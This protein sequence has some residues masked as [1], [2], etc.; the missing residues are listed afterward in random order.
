M[1]VKRLLVFLVA[2]A[3]VHAGSYHRQTLE[4]TSLMS[5]LATLERRHDS[6]LDCNDPG[7]EAECRNLCANSQAKSCSGKNL[8]AVCFQGMCYCGFQP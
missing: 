4:E 7:L 3:T 1:F 8:H 2:A 6:C 5:N